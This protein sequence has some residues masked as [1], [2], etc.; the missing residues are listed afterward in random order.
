MKKLLFQLITPERVMFEEKV[1]EVI[2]PTDNGEI[3][4]LPN[5][6]PLLSLLKHGEIRVKNDDQTTCL[7]CSKGCIEV[8]DKGVRVL[9][10]TA[11]RAEEI[12]EQRALEAKRKAEEMLK[13]AKDEVSFANA[14]AYLERSLTR[15]RV[16][17]RKHKHHL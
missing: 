2:L 13:E 6:V 10:D 9:T 8:H 1:D 15:I 11:E 16:A 17:Q 14:S 12:D 7:A 3:G 4:I 5:H